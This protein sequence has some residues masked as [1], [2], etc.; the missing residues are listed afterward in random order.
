MTNQNGPVTEAQLKHTLEQER[1][2]WRAQWEQNLEQWRA[3]WQTSLERSKAQNQSTIEMFRAT[4]S[5]G[6][7]SLKTVLIINGGAIMVLMALMGQL[8]AREDVQVE[9]IAQLALSMQWF[10]SGLIAAVFAPGAAYVSQSAYTR[11]KGR[12]G[13]TF[14]ALAV[15]L[16]IGSVASFSIGAWSSTNNFKEIAGLI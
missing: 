9:L 14:L 1:D 7:T 3:E 6:S 15:A 16:F 2:H 5:F 8:L 12:L 13:H 11:D 10:L 4:I